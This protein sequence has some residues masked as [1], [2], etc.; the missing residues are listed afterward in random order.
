MNSL[1]CGDNLKAINGLFQAVNSLR[2]V[3]S[4]FQSV[5]SLLKHV[6]DP[7]D[8]GTFMH[9]AQAANALLRCHFLPIKHT[10]H[11]H[12]TYGKKILNQT[13]MIILTMKFF[14]FSRNLLSNQ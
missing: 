3:N 5:N 4:L 7:W 11:I 10:G 6:N 8:D 9:N 1:F 13:N 2:A 14:Y 12:S